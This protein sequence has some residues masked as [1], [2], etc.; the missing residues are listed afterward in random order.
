MFALYN[1][2]SL[3]KCR[4]SYQNP[5][6][7]QDQTIP[8]LLDGRDLLGIANTGTGK[9]AVFLIPLLNKIIQNRGQKFLIITPTREITEQINTEIYHLSKNLNLYSVLCVGGMNIK[10]QTQNIRRGFNIIVGTPE[11]LLDLGNHSI[12]NFR[13]F[14][15]IVL[16]EVDRMLDMGFIQDIMNIMGKFPENRHS[17]FFSAT[18][19]NEVNKI[20][21]TFAK[22]HIKVSTKSAETSNNVN[23]D[24]VKF[25]DKNERNSLLEEMLCNNDFKKVIIFVGTKHGV[26]RLATNLF[27]KGY[28]VDSIHGNK[29]QPQRRKALENFKNGRAKI[30]VAN[31]VASRGLDIPNV[32]HVINYDLPETYD[33]YVHRIGRT[34]R[35][36]QIGTALTFIEHR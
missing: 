34:G 27:D 7:I 16:D 8:H 29:T 32:S 13:H 36:S 15:N 20:L 21:D 3:K 35:A 19:T 23:Q 6:P 30:L 31:D 2:N 9:T 25:K 22:D 4:C 17:M 18:T 24:I 1:D 33:D 11:R 5:T 26:N 10:I 14:E 28:K 12:L